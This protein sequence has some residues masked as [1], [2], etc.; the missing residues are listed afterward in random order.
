MPRH[1]FVITVSHQNSERP[2]TS[3]T[4]SHAAGVSLRSTRNLHVLHIGSRHSPISAFRHQAAIDKLSHVPSSAGKGA[5]SG[6]ALSTPVDFAELQAVARQVAKATGREIHLRL[7]LGADPGPLVTISGDLND[8]TITLHPVAT[9]KLP[10]N[11][12]A[13]IFVHEFAHLVENLEYHTQDNTATELKSRYRRCPLC[14]GR[15]LPN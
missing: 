6:S 10:P 8:C 9:R 12:W 5:I 13:F 4:S 11:T 2:I 1:R 15:R 7:K 3:P 14:D